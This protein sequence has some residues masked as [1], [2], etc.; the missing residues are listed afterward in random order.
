MISIPFRSFVF[1]HTEFGGGIDSD[2]ARRMSPD[3]PQHALQLLQDLPPTE[4]PFF[5]SFR[6]P[7]IDKGTQ[8]RE[9]PPSLHAVSDLQMAE[10]PEN[11]FVSVRYSRVGIRMSG[12]GRHP[13]AVLVG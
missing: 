2:M 1:T 9:S 4:R 6:Y 8:D 10:R 13:G 3:T 11:V 7:G 12:R 5:R